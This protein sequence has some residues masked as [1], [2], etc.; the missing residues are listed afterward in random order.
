MYSPQPVPEFVHAGLAGG[1]NRG[2]RRER[3]AEALTEGTNQRHAGRV[4]VGDIPA[5]QR[6]GGRDL[7]GRSPRL[8]PVLLVPGRSGRIQRK[9]AAG[10]QPALHRATVT[11]L[12]EATRGHAE[13]E[14][15]IAHLHGEH[16]VLRVGV[17]VP[18]PQRNRL[19]GGSEVLGPV[20]VVAHGSPVAAMH[21]ELAGE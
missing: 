2:L 14:L 13:K 16:E 8:A 5:E 3:C 10:Y 17:L 15:R 21:R 7:G 6:R 4:D 18:G 11:L 12:P 20:Q 9:V 1:Q 19:I